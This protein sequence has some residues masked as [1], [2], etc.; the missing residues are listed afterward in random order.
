MKG[1][2]RRPSPAMA[3]AALA[4]VFAMV[5]TAVAGTDGLTNKITK[6]KVKT[7]AKKQ[8]DKA[9]PGLSVLKAK[10]ADT[11]T[12]AAA[13]AA[14]SVGSGQLSDGGVRAAD[15]G[16]ITTVSA[17]GTVAAGASGSLTTGQCPATSPLAI[18]GGGEAI[19]PNVYM[20]INRKSGANGWRYD[21]YNAGAAA[22]AVTV[23]VY[24]LDA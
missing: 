1:T 24:C 14:N 4:L 13:V 10:T 16:P 2:A 23:F 19:G 3:L 22:S 6:P 21:M 18:S 5:G 15:L 12:T 11:A 9:A 20:T 8:I 7:I 17:T